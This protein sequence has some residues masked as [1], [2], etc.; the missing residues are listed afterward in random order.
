MAD[1]FDPLSA[2]RNELNI[3][4]GE[5]TQF[6]TP[7]RSIL[8]FLG[9]SPHRTWTIHRPFGGTLNALSREFV[10][11]DYS[12]DQLRENIVEEGKRLI[13]H[14][15][16]RMGRVVA[17][18]VLRDKWAIRLLLPFV[19]DYFLWRISP[20]ILREVAEAIFGMTDMQNFI[21]SIRLMSTKRTTTPPARIEKA[22]D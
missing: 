3:L 21:L 7:K 11:M 19:A 10:E 2:E 14:N 4:N 5:G 6:K 9:G 8:R 15:A 16:H 13:A 22:G 20:A 17:I 12:E 1:Q 18:A